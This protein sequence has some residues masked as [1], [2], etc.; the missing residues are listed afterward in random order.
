MTDG[1][2]LL[3]VDDQPRNLDA[4]ETILAASGVSFVRDVYPTI[5]ASW[6]GENGMAYIGEYITS[7]G[8]SNMC[9]G[10]AGFT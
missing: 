4:L 8:E 6:R 10:D 5:A 3:L 7:N 2:K 9:S 1:P